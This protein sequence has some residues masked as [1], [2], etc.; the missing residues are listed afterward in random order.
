[1][2][3]IPRHRPRALALA[4]AACAVL[5]GVLLSLLSRP[6]L[7]SGTVTLASREVTEEDGRWKLKMSIDFG[8][9]PQLPHIPMI[10]SFTPMVLYERALTDKSPEKPVLIKMPLSNQTTNNESMDVGFSDGSG[11]IFKITKFDFVIRRDHGFEAGEYDLKIKREDDGVQMGQVIHLSLKGDNPV[12]DRRA[13][14]FAG[15]KPRKKVDPD[16]AEE[17]TEEKKDE[18]AAEEKKS[19]DGE[20]KKTGEDVPKVPPK[21]GGCGCKV[22]GDEGPNGG[23]IAAL[24]MAAALVLRRRRR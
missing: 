19:E 24:G 6:A 21:Q 1:M 5:V 9:I 7:A 18:P 22:A 14:V 2:R 16:K 10:F 23:A 11:K 15:D 20:E 12:V 8:S 17:K 3:S 4:S 13:M